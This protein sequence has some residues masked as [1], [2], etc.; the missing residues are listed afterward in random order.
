VHDRRKREVVMNRD[1][2]PRFAERVDDLSLSHV[3]MQFLKRMSSGRSGLSKSFF[4]RVSTRC[5]SGIELA[6][7]P[8]ENSGVRDAFDKST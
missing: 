5:G 2:A 1:G 4:L 6:V 8:T 3:K 7:D